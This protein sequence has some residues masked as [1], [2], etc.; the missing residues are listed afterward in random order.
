MPV[1]NGRQSIGDDGSAGRV[2]ER[3]QRE[4]GE[5]RGE[6]RRGEERKGGREC[7]G[8]TAKNRKGR[9]RPNTLREQGDMTA[10]YSE[11]PG[12]VFSCYKNG[13]LAFHLVSV[14]LDTRTGQRM[15]ISRMVT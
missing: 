13:R 5:G 6:E 8:G 1:N 2:I 14:N 10:I 15:K 7:K 12:Q 4:G 3:Q 9:R 11:L